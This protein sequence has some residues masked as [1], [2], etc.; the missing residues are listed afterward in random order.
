[1]LSTFPRCSAGSRIVPESGSGNASASTE[2]C[3]NDFHCMERGHSPAR[4]FQQSKQQPGGWAMLH[5]DHCM[6][7]LHHNAELPWITFSISPVGYV[8]EKLF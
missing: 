7:I 8:L 4:V 6:L 3:G 5:L 1:M 2:S